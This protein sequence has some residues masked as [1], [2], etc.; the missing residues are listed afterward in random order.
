M[1]IF[2]DPSDFFEINLYI[3]NEDGV[4]ACTI[5]ESDAKKSFDED[6]ES[7]WVRFEYPTYGSTLKIQELT[8]NFDEGRAKFDPVAFRHHRCATLLK[9]WS[10]VDEN[11][12]KIPATREN[13][14]T[15]SD[16]VAS[17]ILLEL[18]KM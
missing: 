14:E 1:N 8:F 13:M 10:F 3:G 15:M 9:D 7:H 5:E 16:I 12:N 18:D 2:V 17:T 11:K 4:I 6:Y